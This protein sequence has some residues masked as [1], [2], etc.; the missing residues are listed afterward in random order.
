MPFDREILQGGALISIRFHG[1]VTEADILSSYRRRYEAV[2][3]DGRSCIV[4][5][6]TDV[7]DIEFSPAAAEDLSQ[8][9]KEISE[10]HPHLTFA[11]VHPRHLDY[12]LAR[13][14]AVHENRTGWSLGVFQ[15]RAEVES[16]LAERGILLGFAADGSI[17]NCSIQE[18]LEPARLRRLQ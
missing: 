13:L 8:L 5:D 9:A 3:P 12:G 16:W 18:D 2:L 17:A 15:S 10:R 6:F 4:A 14:Q 11:G 7:E 1:F